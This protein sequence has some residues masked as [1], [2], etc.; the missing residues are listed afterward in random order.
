[1]KLLII[2]DQLATLS[3]LEKGIDWGSIGFTEVDTAQNAMEARL[4]FAKK[5][6]DVML[7]DIE[8]PVETGIEFSKW[9]RD[10]EYNTKIIFLTCH[11]DFHY[12]QEAISL[13]ASD[14]I[15]QPSP[16]H[17]IKDK[18]NKVVED[19]KKQQAQSKIED[20]GMAYIRQQSSFNSSV[21]RSYLIGSVDIG[22]LKNIPDFLNVD[23]E[24]YMVLIHMVQR[25][26]KM[27]DWSTATLKQ[28]LENVLQDIF[29]PEK[30]SFVV[31]YMEDNSYAFTV[32]GKNNTSLPRS[33]L[34]ANLK[35]LESMY[36]MYMPCALAFYVIGPSSIESMPNAWE[37]LVQIRNHNITGKKGLYIEQDT[38]TTEEYK[39]QY[40]RWKMILENEGAS[41]MEE[42]VIRSL[43]ELS[44]QGRLNERTLLAF[45]RDLTRMIMAVKVDG[46]ENLFQFESLASNKRYINAM[47]SL[48][49]M[50]AYI[51]EMAEVLRHIEYDSGDNIVKTVMDYI[52]EH[53]SENIR[54]EDLTNLLHLNEDYLTRI[55]KKETGQSIKTYIIKRKMDTAREL[56]QT[57]SLS[58]SS[59]AIQ[60]GYNNF[61]HFSASYKKEFGITPAEEKGQK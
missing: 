42:D 53:L 47:H 18:V 44:S 9:V 54:K 59:V 38:N 21:W 35:Y 58:V 43:H 4:S 50:E 14:Y 5:V 27:K 34:H 23:E 39:P 60:L 13:N 2:D 6:P 37:K 8:M 49:E 3:G 20:L 52:D 12:A 30:Y 19:L 26:E 7:C 61:S 56:L 57:T 29:V 32:Q 46:E 28:A 31:S 15:V 51:H 41:A 33:D 22:E 11:S 48:P 36:D 45:H 55:F 25:T 17:R 40:Y 24:A 1:M 16:Y 10:Q